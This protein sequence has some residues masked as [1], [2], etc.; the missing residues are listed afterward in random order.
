MRKGQVVPRFS[1]EN[2]LPHG[3]ELGGDLGKEAIISL[4]W[5]E[6]AKGAC[7]DFWD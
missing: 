7:L 3:E 5:P 4:G 2:N 6:L 1:T